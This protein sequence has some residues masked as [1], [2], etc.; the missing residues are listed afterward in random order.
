MREGGAQAMRY[1]RNANRS[2]PRPE[3]STGAAAKRE[4]GGSNP[5]EPKRLDGGRAA[6]SLQGMSS[7][8]LKTPTT[9]LWLSALVIAGAL[10]VRFAPEWG[11]LSGLGAP[12]ST[13]TP[14]DRGAD[15]PV[16][17]PATEP[18]ERV[19]GT[20]V[21]FRSEALLE[22]HFRKHGREVGA[23]SA[24]EYL[25]RAQ[26]LRDRAAGGSMLE[27]V[28]ADG[29]VTRFDR[30]NGAFIAFGVDGVI[31]TFFRPNDGERYF[32]RQAARPRGAP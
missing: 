10:V 6:A 3:V 21:G 15:P 23:G 11:H 20:R 13:G 9:V 16:G 5:R 17:S 4:S 22:E 31:R 1:P 14:A 24:S 12:G 28:R 7:H 29:V 26:A 32:E 19:F 18:G 25:R 30:A 27:R 2:G 8:P